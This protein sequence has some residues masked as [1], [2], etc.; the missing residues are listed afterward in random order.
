MCNKWKVESHFNVKETS[1]KCKRNGIYM[2]LIIIKL[3]VLK[4]RSTSYVHKK[5]LIFI[6]TN[7]TLKKSEDKI[8]ETS[9]CDM[10]RLNNT[11][12][13][14]LCGDNCF[15]HYFIWEFKKKIL[16]GTANCTLKN[17]KKHA[18]VN[19]FPPSSSTLREKKN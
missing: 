11:N 1:F 10:Y 18:A 8:E 15:F 13:F 3:I 4:Q 14:S 5:R 17:S 19:L 9:A 12:N 6:S 7:T 2:N 16:K